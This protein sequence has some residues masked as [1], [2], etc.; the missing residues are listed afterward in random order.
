M[1][2]LIRNKDCITHILL[3]NA[4]KTIKK[5]TAKRSLLRFV[6]T[7][8]VASLGRAWRICRRNVG[9]SRLPN[10]YRY[11]GNTDKPCNT[12]QRLVWLEVTQINQR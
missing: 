6:H 2:W 1:V 10:K 11:T 8:L 9:H 4:I 3:N 12:N 7:L 5:T